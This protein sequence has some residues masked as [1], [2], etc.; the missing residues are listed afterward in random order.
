MS[1]SGGINSAL[2]KLNDDEFCRVAAGY[3]AARDSLEKLI[4]ECDNNLS[5]VGRAYG[6][7]FKL[8]GVSPTILRRELRLRGLGV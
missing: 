1:Q 6:D 4:R 3:L 2:S 5:E 8:W 7:R